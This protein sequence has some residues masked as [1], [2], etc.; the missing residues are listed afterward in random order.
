M[1]FN[2]YEPRPAIHVWGS[3]CA[4]LWVPIPVCSSAARARDLSVLGHRDL[5]RGTA[6]P[7][8]TRARPGVSASAIALGGY[9]SCAPVT[10]GTIKCW[11]FNG[12]GELGIGSTANQLRP[13]DVDLGTGAYACLRVGERG[14]PVMFACNYMRIISGSPRVCG[15]G[16]GSLAGMA[17]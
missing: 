6:S 2:A 12:N 15:G 9:H 7:T 5:G 8:N 14:L 11:G 17:Q 10:G 4:L 1:S 3:R 16:G 13:V